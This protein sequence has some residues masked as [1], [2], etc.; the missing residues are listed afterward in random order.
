MQQT[1]D[2]FQIKHFIIFW[3]Q[4]SVFD[5]TFKCSDIKDKL[6]AHASGSDKQVTVSG[7]NH[8]FGVKNKEAEDVI[9][10]ILGLCVRWP[11]FLDKGER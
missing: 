3:E 9:C 10:L 2:T 5:T 8:A 6:I 7:M 11:A 4:A 1:I